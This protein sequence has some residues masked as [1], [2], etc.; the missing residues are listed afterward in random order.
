M[1]IGQSEVET[2]PFVTCSY[3]S[4]FTYCWRL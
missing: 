4:T 1:S 3:S 2:V